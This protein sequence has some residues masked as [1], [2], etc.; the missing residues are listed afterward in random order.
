VNR[1]SDIIAMA[2]ERRA[3]LADLKDGRTDAYRVVD[4][5]GDG[6]P[7]VFIDSFAGHW[8]V[9]TKEAT[10]PRALLNTSE[11]GW[12]SLW[13]K[14]LDQQDKTSPQFMAGEQKPEFLIRENGLA[15]QIDFQAGYSQGIFLDQR[16]QRERIRTSLQPGERMLNLFAYTC[17]FSVAGAAAGAQTES[18]DLSRPYLDWGKRNF[19]ANGFPTEGHFFCRGDSFDWMRRLANKGH[20]YRL[21]VLDPPTFSRNQE[22]KLWRVEKDYPALVKAA[23]QLTTPGG[24]V[25]CCT[26]HH[27]IS[28]PAFRSML[29]AGAVEAQRTIQDLSMG[30]QPEDFT[31]EPYLKVVWLRV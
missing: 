28:L 16:Y 27:G 25:L 26:N 24:E 2:L 20:R 22:G 11:F 30:G 3:G 1:L 14:Q 4:G 15:Y 29:R 9:Q 31:A 17:A 21:V 19:E 6:L 13:W 12:R 7:G 18:I 8:L 10:F 23:L 5:A